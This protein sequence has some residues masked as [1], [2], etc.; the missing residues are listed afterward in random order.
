[1]EKVSQ[2]G[3]VKMI[4]SDTP[5]KLGNPDVYAAFSHLECIA[6]G[7]LHIALKIERAQAR[8]NRNSLCCYVVVLISSV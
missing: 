1:M 5:T 2:T 8:M 4:F 3:D 6:T 7:P